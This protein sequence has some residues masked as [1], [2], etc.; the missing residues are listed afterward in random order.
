L[1]T[2]QADGTWT[3]TTSDQAKSNCTGSS[4]EK[5]AMGTHTVTILDVAGHVLAQGS[6]TLTP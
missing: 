5:L 1:F 3:Y 2:R 4:G 6:F